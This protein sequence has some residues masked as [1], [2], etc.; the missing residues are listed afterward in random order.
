MGGGDSGSTSGGDSGSCKCTKTLL[1]SV[2]VTHAFRH[3]IAAFSRL[4]LSVQQN[5]VLMLQERVTVRN[6]R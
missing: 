3:V 6:D 4:T 2:A 5:C 1:S